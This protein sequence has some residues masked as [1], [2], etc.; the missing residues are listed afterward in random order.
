MKMSFE[1]RESGF[2]VS[3]PNPCYIQ[4]LVGWGLLASILQI[5]S[6]LL[7]GLDE[8][9]DVVLRGQEQQQGEMQM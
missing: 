1:L 5:S 8:P 6:Y 7:C 4:P 3:I 2:W 9:R